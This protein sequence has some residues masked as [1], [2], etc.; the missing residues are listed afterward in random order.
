MSCRLPVDWRIW[1]EQGIEE[2]DGIEHE[3]GI[4]DF[5]PEQNIQ[6]WANGI[7]IRIFR[8]HFRSI[9]NCWICMPMFLLYEQKEFI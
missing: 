3:L 2:S 1:N 8:R 9:Y 5:F 7:F 6:Q 4:I